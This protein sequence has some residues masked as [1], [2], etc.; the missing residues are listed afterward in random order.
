[1]REEIRRV[2][3][4]SKTSMIGLLNE[5]YRKVRDAKVRVE[6]LYEIGQMN[7]VCKLLHDGRLTE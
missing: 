3:E 6:K 2:C 5:P 4:D 7:E 1:M